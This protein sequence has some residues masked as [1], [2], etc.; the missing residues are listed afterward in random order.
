MILLVYLYYT[1][2][3]KKDNINQE[4]LRKL[5]K[6]AAAMGITVGLSAPIYI[7]HVLFNVPLAELFTITVLLEQILI[8]I[9][10]CHK[11]T[12]MMCKKC[13]SKELSLTDWLHILLTGCII[14]RYITAWHNDRLYVSCFL[15]N[16]ILWRCKLSWSLSTEV[17][18]V[19]AC[20]PLHEL[21]LEFYAA[22]VTWL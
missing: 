10:L 15:D 13:F 3:L 4:N 2:K 21:M 9:T 20:A 16:I 18:H 1:Y 5:H 17:L 14:F 19:V 12:H 6:I 8:V 22:Y 11:K 7:I